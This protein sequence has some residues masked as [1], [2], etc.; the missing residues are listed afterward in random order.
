F[1][2][3]NPL[4]CFVIPEGRKAA[5][6][7]CDIVPNGAPAE[8]VDILVIAE[9][10]TEAEL[11]KFH[12]DAE[13]LVGK[14][15]ATEPFKSRKSDFNVRALDLIEPVSGVDRPRTHEDRRTM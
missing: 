3:S 13:R 14:L 6:H 9:G 2:L 11:P 1:W 5:G 7:V 12:K 10:Y 15:F 4:M 8:K